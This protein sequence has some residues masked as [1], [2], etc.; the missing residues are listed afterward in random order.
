MPNR[1]QR[2]FSCSFI[3][4]IYS[5]GWR[6]GARPGRVRDVPHVERPTRTKSLVQPLHVEVGKKI[7]RQARF[8]AEWIHAQADEHAVGE[9]PNVGVRR[10][11]QKAC[12]RPICLYE[13]LAA[14]EPF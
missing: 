7:H 5:W 1:A 10:A 13:P 2:N 3:S 11:V 8:A 4:R 14:A 12:F 6:L 9:L